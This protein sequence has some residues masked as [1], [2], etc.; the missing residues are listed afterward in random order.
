MHLM[1]Y[2]TSAIKESIQ[3]SNIA[4]NEI[5]E[6]KKEIAAQNERLLNLQKKNSEIYYSS[7]QNNKYLDAM[8]KTSKKGCVYFILFCVILILIMILLK[9][10]LF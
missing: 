7:H 9:I 4:K 10:A 8:F 6:I 2:S 1:T 3:I 5:I